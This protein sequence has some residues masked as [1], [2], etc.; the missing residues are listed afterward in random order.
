[1][2]HTDPALIV[3][4]VVAWV[5]GSDLSR[6]PG[7]PAGCD[8]R[9]CSPACGDEADAAGA[10]RNWQEPAAVLEVSVPAALLPAGQLPAAW[11]EQPAARSQP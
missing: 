10:L 5:C 11:P 4:W 2:L 8:L 3:N 6:C 1:M 7:S 9:C